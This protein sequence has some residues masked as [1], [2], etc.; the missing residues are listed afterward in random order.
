M[1]LGF[2]SQVESII[3]NTQ[4]DENE[5]ISRLKDL[6][7]DFEPE[8]KK[9]ALPISD[10]IFEVLHQIKDE[11]GSTNYI[12]SHFPNF[13]KTFGGFNLGELVVIGG[14]PSMG[15]TQLLVNLAMNVSQQFPVAFFSYEVSAPLLSHRFI[16]CLT[17]IPVNELI[18]HRLSEE[19]KNELSSIEERFSKHKIYLMDFSNTSI[20]SL[21]NLCKKHVSENKVKMIIVDYL[22]MM[23]S[24]KYR[25]NRETEV[26]YIIRELKNLAKSLNVCIIV[27]SQLSREVDKRESGQLPIITDLRESGAIEQTADQVILMYR[28]EYYNIY[29]DEFGNSTANLTELIMAKNK[30]GV[31]GNI[32][33]Y[34]NKQFTS[35]SEYNVSMNNEFDFKNS[36]MF[37]IN[38][39]DVNENPF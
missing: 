31:L 39:P 33:L 9:E 1:N 28:P 21:K 32:K 27:A 24:Y 34:R 4:N 23:S 14:R 5:L 16:S 35:F 2:K 17:G 36:R 29:L 38:I 37:E 12:P 18:Q 22:Q 11:Q 20:E 30:N 3:N 8:Q 6:I 13:D 26:A 19:R 10:L 25:N 15:K 7:L